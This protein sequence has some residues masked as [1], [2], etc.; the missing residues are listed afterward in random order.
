MISSTNTHNSFESKKS[1]CCDC[2]VSLQV[3]QLLEVQSKL[4]VGLEDVLVVGVASGD[5][6]ITHLLREL[7]R[8]WLLRAESKQ[9]TACALFSKGDL[10]CLLHLGDDR[11]HLVNVHLH[12]PRLRADGAVRKGRG[13]QIACHQHPRI[14]ESSRLRRAI[15]DATVGLGTILL[16][17]LRRFRQGQFD[18]VPI[19]LLHQ[20]TQ[21]SLEELAAGRDPW[22][23]PIVGLI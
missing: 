10:G 7:A 8:R 11:P 22:R 14:G 23:V 6:Q 2:R 21:V 12:L 18:P 20:S 5:V 16:R 13:V 19:A 3:G 4:R 1:C 15:G 17:L 9:P